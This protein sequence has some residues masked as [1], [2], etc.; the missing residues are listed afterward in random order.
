MEE[1]ETPIS[2][3]G[4]GGNTVVSIIKQFVTDVGCLELESG[5]SWHSFDIPEHKN[6]GPCTRI[7]YNRV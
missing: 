1:T 2:G 3:I 5:L 4:I 6:N 7:D